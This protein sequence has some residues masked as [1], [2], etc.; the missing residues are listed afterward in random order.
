MAERRHRRV[1]DLVEDSRHWDARDMIRNLEEEMARLEQGLGHM[2]FD[3][4]GRAITLCP[5][6]LPM[7][8]KFE[9]KE[10]GDE[11]GLK[12]SLPSVEKEDVRLYVTRDTIEVRA[13]SE[14]RACRPYYLSVDTPWSVDS[15]DAKVTFEGGMLTVR[16]RKLRKIR[17]PVK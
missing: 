14:G 17:V 7:T 16:T 5:S 6:P 15:E 4:E 10:E 3:S 8:P 11:F 1:Q 2:I 9:T 12:V 13:V